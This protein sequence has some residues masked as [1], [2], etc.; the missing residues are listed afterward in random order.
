M[1]IKILQSE[2][3]IARHG[4]SLFVCLEGQNLKF[5]PSCR[6]RKDGSDFTKDSS[7]SDG[8]Y[9]FCRNCRK[10]KNSVFPPGRI[11][12]R[13]TQG[14]RKRRKHACSILQGNLN[15]GKIKKGVCLVCDSSLGVEGHHEDYAKPLEVLWLCREHHLG[16][17]KIK[18]R[19][20]SMASF[21]VRGLQVL[22]FIS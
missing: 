20:L 10:I 21:Y 16:L 4:L 6:T 1:D 17:H 9:G 22:F 5:C 11:P 15:S 19:D 2:K 12:L 3:G 18:R 13:L 14:E 7:R 8:L